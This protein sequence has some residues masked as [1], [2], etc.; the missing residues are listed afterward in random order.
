M[1]SERLTG[2]MQ[3]RVHITE[4]KGQSYRLRQSKRHLTSENKP[5]AK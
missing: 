3:D 5:Q 1:G 2:A 4:A